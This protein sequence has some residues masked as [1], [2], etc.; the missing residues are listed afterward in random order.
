MKTAGIYDKE[1][2]MIEATA[3]VTAT[4]TGSAIDVH[5]DDFYEMNV[6]AIFPK[7]TGTTPKCVLK[8][9]GS[10][11]KVTWKD[12]YVFPDIEAAGEYNAKFR[13]KGRY[14]RAVATISGTSPNFG[15]VKVGYSAGGVL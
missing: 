3:D 12:I 15:L 7:A 13:G 2:M 9:Q 6:R 1:L 4:V 5:G 10:D 11:D 8:I 14:R